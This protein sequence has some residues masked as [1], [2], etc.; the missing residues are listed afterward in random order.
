[1]G[2]SR[3][4]FDLI[5]P[6]GRLDVGGKGP[7]GQSRLYKDDFTFYWDQAVLKIVWFFFRFYLL[8]TANWVIPGDSGWRTDPVASLIFQ[9]V[10]DEYVERMK[11]RG[12]MYKAIDPTYLKW[13]PF[14]AP[15]ATGPTW[16]S[17]NPVEVSREEGKSQVSV[18][19]VWTCCCWH[20]HRVMLTHFTSLWCDNV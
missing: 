11:R 3:F 5:L 4:F 19:A 8:L 20:A 18:K 15:A 17:E 13:T 1:M 14:V 16:Y 10:I 12:S 9:D 2:S 7:W 6:W